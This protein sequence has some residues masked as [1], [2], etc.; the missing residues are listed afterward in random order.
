MKYYI[1]F[2]LLFS[3]NAN[4]QLAV[5]QVSDLDFGFATNGDVE[6]TVPPNTIETSENASFL[7]V[8]PINTSY[9]IILPRRIDMSHSSGVG[10]KIRVSNPTSYPAEGANG[11]LGP[12]GQQYLYV[13]GTRQSIGQNLTSGSYSATFTVE[14]V[15]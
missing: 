4:A 2:L 6:K 8:G 3:F 11:F 1:F 5:T 9:S 7:V 14:V 15:L 13:G 10:K 12:T